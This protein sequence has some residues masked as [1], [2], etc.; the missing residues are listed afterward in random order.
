MVESRFVKPIVYFMACA[1]LACV[2]YNSQ[3]SSSETTEL[4]SDHELKAMQDEVREQLVEAAKR[5][6]LAKKHREQALKLSYKAAEDRTAAQILRRKGEL[7][8]K[9]AV[10][11][12]E[13]TR[14]NKAEERVKRLKSKAADLDSAAD[15]DAAQA[16]K[17]KEDVLTLQS[18]AATL[19]EKA[20]EEGSKMTV[21]REATAKEAASIPLLLSQADAAEQKAAQLKRSAAARMGESRR[22]ESRATALDRLADQKER[23]AHLLRTRLVS[24]VSAKTSDLAKRRGVR[25]EVARRLGVDPASH[26]DAVHDEIQ[27]ALA[28]RA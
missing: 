9:Q 6:A 27:R 8:K 23:E 7:A 5:R 17:L 19:D 10:L 24:V 25:E 2:V 13:K 4:E 22:K 11:S 16:D 26:A 12:K 1:L 3:R 28:A 21:V 20:Q 14:A 18:K 15:K